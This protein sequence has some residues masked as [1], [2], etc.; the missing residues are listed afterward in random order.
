VA[1][2]AIRSEGEDGAAFV[3]LRTLVQEKR[4]VTLLLAARLWASSGG[5]YALGDPV[6]IKATDKGCAGQGARE[7][8][9][10]EIAA[11]RLLGA[12]GGH[13]NVLPL[14]DAMEDED[15]IY[16]VLPYVPDGD[17]YYRLR[18]SP[19]PFAMDEARRIFVGVCRGL[20]FM[21]GLGLAHR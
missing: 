12:A 19:G 21:A 8:A 2:P 14:L 20:S 9:C 4:R 15:Y 7:D 5:T 10:R 18:A 6:V 11:M 16:T 13:R 1:S 17:L 3:L